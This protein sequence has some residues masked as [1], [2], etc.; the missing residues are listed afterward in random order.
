MRICWSCCQWPSFFVPFCTFYYLHHPSPL[1]IICSSFIAITLTSLQLIHLKRATFIS[2][3][4]MLICQK[5]PHTSGLFKYERCLPTLTWCLCANVRETVA[6]YL[7]LISLAASWLRVSCGK[8]LC[9]SWRPSRI[10]LWYPKQRS[11]WVKQTASG[12][13][14]GMQPLCPSPLSLFSYWQQWGSTPGQTFL[15]WPIIAC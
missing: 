9:L 15:W 10:S 7:S 11:Q 12:E 4:K 2:L 3:N 14:R 5:S 1:F 8:A 13:K 6:A